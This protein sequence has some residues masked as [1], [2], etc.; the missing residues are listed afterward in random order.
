MKLPYGYGMLNTIPYGTFFYYAMRCRDF[1]EN[2]KEDKSGMIYRDLPY[3][4]KIYRGYMTPDKEY[5]LRFVCMVPPAND[6]YNNKTGYLNMIEL[7]P[8]SV[9][10]NPDKPE[11][12]W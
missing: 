8:K 6:Y 4:L 9:Y 2:Y 3:R 1:P 11:D 5:W 10:D 7:V 12:W